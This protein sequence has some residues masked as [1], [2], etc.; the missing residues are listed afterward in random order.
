MSGSFLDTSADRN[1]L[2]PERPE[3][4]G[5]SSSSG[6]VIERGSTKERQVASDSDAIGGA[7]SAVGGPACAA[8]NLKEV[9]PRQQVFHE[10]VTTESNYVAIL[11]CVAKIAQV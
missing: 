3:V 2:S 7:A 9:G 11:D 4:G 5:G 1:I 10:L 6:G 8:V